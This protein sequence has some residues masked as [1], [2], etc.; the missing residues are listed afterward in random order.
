MRAGFLLTAF[1]L[2]SSCGGVGPHDTPS[3]LEQF[4][5]MFNKTFETPKDN[6]NRSFAT[7]A[8]G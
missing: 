7:G 8:C 5:V 3:Q 4:A 6:V 2:L 1:I